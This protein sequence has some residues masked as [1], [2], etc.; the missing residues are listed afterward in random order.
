[1][2]LSTRAFLRAIR[3]EV[4]GCFCFL[5]RFM[6]YVF[7][8]G[9]MQAFYDFVA[10]FTDEEVE[11]QLIGQ[12]LYVPS[13]VLDVDAELV[14]T[15]QRLGR[16]DRKGFHPSITLLDLLNSLTERKIVVNDKTA[17][18]F[19]CGRNVLKEGIVE[20]GAEEGHVL[21]TNERGEVLG[22][23]KITGAGVTNKLDRGD[24]LRRER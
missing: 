17:W 8:L 21:V 10:E 4:R 20:R 9:C 3:L 19:L 23:G 11:S 5:R 18:L 14:Y 15:S 6:N 1:M 2:R 24:F 7:L 13:E 16:I 12:E 22:Y